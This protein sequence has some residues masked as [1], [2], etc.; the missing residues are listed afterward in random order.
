MSLAGMRCRQ[1]EKLKPVVV[2]DPSPPAT[3]DGKIVEYHGFVPVYPFMY[4]MLR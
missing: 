1:V 2:P 4:S 3:S